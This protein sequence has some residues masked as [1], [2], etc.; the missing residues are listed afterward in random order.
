LRRLQRAGQP[1][2]VILG[3]DKQELGIVSLEDILKT[4]FGEV[5]L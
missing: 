4:I 2:A 3:R 1:L 5:K